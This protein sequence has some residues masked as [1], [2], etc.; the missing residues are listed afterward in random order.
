MN[1]EWFCLKQRAASGR[2]TSCKSS[3]IGLPPIQVSRIGLRDSFLRIPQTASRL[4]KQA[5]SESSI[6]SYATAGRRPTGY[7]SVCHA[8]A[9]PRETSSPTLLLDGLTVTAELRISSDEKDMLLPDGTRFTSSF[10]SVSPRVSLQR[11]IAGGDLIY[12]SVAQGSKP[13]GF[14]ARTELPDELKSFGEEN[15]WHYEIGYKASALDR[16]ATLALS[17]FYIDWTRQQLTSSFER[18]DGP[19]IIY[20]ENAGKTRVLGLEIAVRYQP[21]DGVDL[22]LTYALADAE[23]RRFDVAEQAALTGDPSVRGNKTPRAPRQMA[24]AFGEYSRGLTG[25]IDAFLRLDLIYEGK[26]YAQ[27]HNLAHSGDK[28][29]LNMRLGIDLGDAQFSLWGKNLFDDR[30]AVSILRFRD[31]AGFDSFRAPRAFGI[32]LPRGRQVGV[33]ASYAF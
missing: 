6:L 12:A 19:S 32:T 20:T 25:E 17:A 28:F 29:I 3:S 26:R 16:R 23:F 9:T 31:F 8:L 24:T 22:G 1:R 15:A 5:E 10:A 13:G 2:P 4:S 14:N 18:P 27:V 11:I 7:G 33:S 30:T 21:A